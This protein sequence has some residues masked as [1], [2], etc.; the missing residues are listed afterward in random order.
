M[1]NYINNPD[2][3]KY[4]N[5]ADTLSFDQMCELTAITHA[6]TDGLTEN[7]QVAITVSLFLYLW[8]E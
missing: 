3:K 1:C 2:N 8:S 4:V 6:E 7:E 5:P